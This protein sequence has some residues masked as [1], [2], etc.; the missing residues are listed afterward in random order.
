M[1]YMNCVMSV[2]V[3]A[4][5]PVDFRLDFRASFLSVLNTLKNSSLDEKNELVNSPFVFVLP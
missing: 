3:I 2:H 5:V 1:S 4:L